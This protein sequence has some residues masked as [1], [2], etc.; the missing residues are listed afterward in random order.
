MNGNA[1]DEPYTNTPTN[2]YEGVDFPLLVEE[3]CIFVMGDNRQGS[4]DSRSDKVGFIKE[5]YILGKAL[6]RMMPFGQFKIG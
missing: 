3:G 5:E 6:F 4:T 2:L 1:L